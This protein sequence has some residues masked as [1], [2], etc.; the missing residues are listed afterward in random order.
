MSSEIRQLDTCDV[1]DSAKG[2]SRIGLIPSCLMT[3]PFQIIV[4]SRSGDLE[5]N[6]NTHVLE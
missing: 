2:G 6:I 5:T 1:V 4:R 3:H